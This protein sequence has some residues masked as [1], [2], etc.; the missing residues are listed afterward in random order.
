MRSLI[1][2][3]GVGRAKRG[4]AAGCVGALS[5]ALG[6][7]APLAPPLEKEP[8]SELGQAAPRLHFSAHRADAGLPVEWEPLIIRRDKRP[9]RY[10]LTP[11]AEQGYE[12]VV[13][14]AEAQAA[15]TGLIRRVTVDPARYPVI[16][17]HW[18]VD[19]LIDQADLTDRTLSDA[20]VRII[21][22]FD[23]DHGKLSWREQSL[24]EM[25][26][27]VSGRDMPY[28]TLMY[29]WENRQPV[30]AV[31]DNA[32]TGRIKKIVAASGPQG[33]GGWREFRRDYAQDFLRAFGE[34]P[35]RLVAVGVLTDTDNTGASAV[36]YYGDI[37]FLAGP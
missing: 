21:L 25:A 20:P 7:C 34:A 29:V 24:A 35:G 36:G 4:C 23:G 6:A 16:R 5:L 31:L 37:D 15:A 13:L 2:L 30:G 14:R 8:S 26:K 9:T 12:R 32:H 3:S 17:W 28:A 10:R 22:A 18:R 19:Q 27:L 33:L 11:V 1:F